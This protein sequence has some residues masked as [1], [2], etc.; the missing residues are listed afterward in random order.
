MMCK[1]IPGGGGRKMG[2]FPVMIIHQRRRNIEHDVLEDFRKKT[3]D[4][5]FFICKIILVTKFTI[6]RIYIAPYRVEGI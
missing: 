5:F 1:S 3:N 2:E 6:I 4:F